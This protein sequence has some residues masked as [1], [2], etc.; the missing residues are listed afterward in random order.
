MRREEGRRDPRAAQPGSGVRPGP[1][2]RGRAS[3]QEASARPTRAGRGAGAG[4]AGEGRDPAAEGR[5]YITNNP[6]LK[7]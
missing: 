1:A 7:L 6:G 3:S 5:N 4:A 2:P